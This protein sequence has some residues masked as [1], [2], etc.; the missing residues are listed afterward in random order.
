V[1]NQAAVLE[2][3]RI[4]L[5]GTGVE[6]LSDPEVARLYLGAGARGAVGA[7]VVDPGA[8]MIP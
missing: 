1:A 5:V 2:A 6:L 8:L 7:A 3:G 4:A